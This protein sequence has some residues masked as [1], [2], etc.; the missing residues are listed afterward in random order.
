LP[1]PPFTSVGDLPLG[2]QRASLREVLDR[3]GTG[4]R[5]RMAVAERLARVSRLTQATGHL[6]RVVAFRWFV[7][8]T[9]EPHDADVFRVRDNAFD[10]GILPSDAALRFDQAVAEAPCGTSVAWVRRLAA[11]GGAQAAVESRE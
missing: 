2:V 7:T 10:A 6:A 8:D 1:L 4:S 11:F 9:L 5:Q 3:F